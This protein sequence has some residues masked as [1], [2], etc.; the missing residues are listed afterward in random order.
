MSASRPWPAPAKVNLG[1][2]VVGTRPDGYH[3]LESCF[4]PLD[5]ADRL[6]IEAEP[7]STTSVSLEVA[8]VAAGVPGGDENLVVRAARAFL[9][10]AGRPARVA[11]RLEK[12]IPVGAGLG[13]GSSDAATVLR[14]LDA[15]FA[16]A[17]A[18]DRLAAI[19]LRLGADVPFFLDPRPAWVTG[20]GE[21]VE[22]IAPFPALDLLLVTPAPPLATAEVFRA[23][24][25]ALTPGSHDRRMPPLRGIPGRTLVAALASKEADHAGIAA[26][27]PPQGLAELLANDLEPV[28]ARLCPGILRVRRELER[29]GARVVA[30]S[31]S[32]PTMFGLFDGS[33]ET[34]TAGAQGRF[35][36]TDRVLAVRT[37]GAPLDL[38][39]R[40]GA[41]WGVV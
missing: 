29:L 5:L 4:V 40:A 11:I 38:G 24:D 39:N 26:G 10:A 21:H 36:A 1:L 23:H 19:A 15:A 35:E 12:A 7:A 6:W 16:N 3:L 30:M 22:A 34:T 27:S 33:E 32:G 9:D 31:G 14:A 13:G 18:G 28:A 2:R 17:I 37:L 8:G 20:I 41:S 25:A